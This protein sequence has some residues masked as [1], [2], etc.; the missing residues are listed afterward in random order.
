MIKKYS[1]TGL[2]CPH[3]AARLEKAV[4]R[5]DG[6]KSVRVDFITQKMTLDIDDGDQDN[7]LAGVIAAAK[8]AMPSCELK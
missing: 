2:D 5:A 7:I 3:C 6:V 8:K 4:G 1:L